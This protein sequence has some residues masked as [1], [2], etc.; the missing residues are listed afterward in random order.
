MLLPTKYELDGSGRLVVPGS[1]VKGA[2]RSLHE[3]LMGGCL[4]V[5]DLDFLP[6][7][8][9]PTVSK[10]ADE[11]WRLAIVTEATAPGRATK[12]QVTQVPGDVIWLE[13]RTVGEALGR[14][15]GSGDSLSIDEDWIP[16]TANTLNRFEV[17][18]S[19]AVTGEGGCWRL[20]VGDA[21]ARGKAEKF[22]VAAGYLDDD[23]ETFAVPIEAWEDYERV[24]AGTDDLRLIRQD[25]TKDEFKGWRTERIFAPV[26][27]K[28]SVV[29]Q[30]RRVTGKLW[31]G[32]VLWVRVDEENGV[33]EQLSM[34]AIWRRTG[35]GSVGDR[36]PETLK[37]C[38]DPDD[39]CVSC[40]LFGSADTSGAEIGAVAEQRA[41]S[42]HIRFGN[43]VSAVPVEPAEVMLAP[44]GVPRPGAGQFYLRHERIQRDRGG[45]D[46]DPLL[47][48]ASD[49]ELPSA[50]WG[51]ARHEGVGQPLRQI[52]GRKLYWHGDPAAQTPPRHIARP[53]QVT[54]KDGRE[55]KM[56]TKR[57]LVPAGT[58]LT[59]RIAFDNVPRAELGALLLTLLPG[60]LMHL[61]DKSREPERSTFPYALRLGGGKPLGLGSCTVEVGGFEWWDEAGRYTDQEARQGDPAE[62][63]RQQRADIIKLAAPDARK[64]WPTLARIL[65]T[66]AVDAERIWYPVGGEW[67]NV[68][69]RDESFRFF[70]QTNGAYY[71]RR[72]EPIVPLPDP[73]KP[74]DAQLLEFQDKP[75]PSQNSPSG[76]S[77]YGNQ[78]RGR[79]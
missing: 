36:V 39:L 45:Q 7:Y 69:K 27:W 77:G 5:V 37:P 71:A 20:L 1:A 2:V 75:R 13:A 43:A 56:A 65:R 74:A 47:P 48:A 34:A 60:A 63:I 10:L 32:D 14:A 54:G 64:H 51:A 30:R 29:G 23:A 41:Y 78:R 73:A 66:D 52:R 55:K 58:V 44:M 50:A 76:G 59:Q 22:F 72:V 19:Q 57:N 26:R 38:T 42:G 24:C 35:A 17:T 46:Y 61:P 18:S 40:R 9:E 70:P 11:A 6:V 67:D 8:R 21:G 4:R 33:V 3:S 68:E 53:H 25:D 79:R 62:F 28:D 16:A 31:P 12:V 15:P 49:Q